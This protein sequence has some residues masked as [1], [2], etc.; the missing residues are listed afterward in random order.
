[1][2]ND[3]TEYMLRYNI[4]LGT[5]LIAL[6][7]DWKKEKAAMACRELLTTDGLNAATVFAENLE[8]REKIK[9]YIGQIQE[10][11]KTIKELEKA[12]LLHEE[13]D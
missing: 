10:M 5:A 1:M 7:N 9:K 6:E 13:A 2:Q 8:L 11:S 4:T 12:A 3:D